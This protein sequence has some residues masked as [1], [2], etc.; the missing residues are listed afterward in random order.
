MKRSL[1]GCRIY[2]DS[3]Y[4]KLSARTDYSYSNLASVGDQNLIEHT[5]FAFRLLDSKGDLCGYRLFTVYCGKS[6]ADTDRTF[7]LYYLDFEL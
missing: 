4:S 5:A 2:C 1:V 7:D 3:L 6:L